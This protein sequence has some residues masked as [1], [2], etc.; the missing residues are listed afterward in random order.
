MLRRNRVEKNH[1]IGGGAMMAEVKSNRS[2]TRRRS[3]GEA[4]ILTA[5]T[6]VVAAVGLGLYRQAGMSVSDAL[7]AALA[8]YAALLCVHVL[9]RRSQAIRR[10]TY[11]IERLE[12]EVRRLARGEGK[13]A[14]PPPRPDEILAS[15]RPAPQF[16]PANMAPPAHAHA[17]PRQQAAPQGVQNAGRSNRDPAP[18]AP[19]TARSA[20]ANETRPSAAPSQP[21]QQ[22]SDPV[23]RFWSVRPTEANADQPSRSG[24]ARRT[25]AQP[26]STRYGPDLPASAKTAR[27]PEAPS[28]QAKKPLPESGPSEQVQDLSD[29]PV[30][31][32]VET[33][34]DMIRI[35]SEEI[36][37]PRKGR[38]VDAPPQSTPTAERNAPAEDE[39]EH[40]PDD[41][42]AISASVEAL[43]AAA[44]EMRR[45]KEG[46]SDIEK[47]VLPPFKADPNASAPQPPPLGR[48]HDE[49]AAMADAIASHKL[50]VYLEPV[51]GLTDRKARHFDVS[52]RLRIS[53][54]KRVGAE[55][56]IPL[57]R[58]AGLL[59]LVDATRMARAAIVAR[60]MDERG[61]GGCLFSAI[62]TDSLTS[63]RFLQEFSEA[64]RQSPK[65][66][67]RLIFSISE[68]ELRHVT[69]PQWDTIRHLANSGVRFAIQDLTTLD[70]DL[71]ETRA[72]GFAFVRVS[73]QA[74]IDGLASVDGVLPAADLCQRLSGAGL[75]LVVCGLESEEQLDN[76]LAAGV[77]LGQGPLF[78]VPRPIRAEALR[79]AQSAA[80]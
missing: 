53:E 70:L 78:G 60:H 5:I 6:L 75:T 28:T 17:A 52:L 61:S 51:V 69:V 50:D 23:S 45:P 58:R 42:E 2:R 4:F 35:Y 43:R 30:A 33:I 22:P 37:S 79:P 38:P 41:D 48:E 12:S 34:S 62:S 59:P 68:A 25:A 3:A 9:V 74:V 55:E 71:E 26:D 77:P 19:P 10:L 73:A 64:C 46:R 20:A 13:R 14:G 67:E 31:A 57:A 40:A 21:E 54:D 29:D 24:D 27:E 39:A 80:A 65:L 1:S 44:E 7:L 15:L 47:G 56:Y 11:E 66:R 16:G 72:A 63:E 36:S 32:D 18:P 49:V 76:L 8:L